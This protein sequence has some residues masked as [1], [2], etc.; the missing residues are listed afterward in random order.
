MKTQRLITTLAGCLVGVTLW[1]CAMTDDKDNAL[2]SGPWHV[3]YIEGEGVIDNSP[4]HYQFGEDGQLSGHASC[5]RFS[6]GYELKDGVISIGELATTRK[7]C[8][9]A[10]MEQ[11]QRFLAAL[12]RAHSWKEFSGLMYLYDE[13]GAELLRGAP[14]TEGN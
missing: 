9:R 8:P 14:W 2:L 3:D 4:A 12:K 6:G 13:S 7:M 1:G 11:E 10:L 5:N